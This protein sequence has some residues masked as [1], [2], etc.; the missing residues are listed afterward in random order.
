MFVDFS[1][2]LELESLVHVRLEAILKYYSRGSES[3][4]TQIGSGSNLLTSLTH[5]HFIESVQM[6]PA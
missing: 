4:K 6:T 1:T 3:S 2:G 5:S